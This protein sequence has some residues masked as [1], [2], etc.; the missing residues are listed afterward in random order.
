MSYDWNKTRDILRERGLTQEID[1]DECGSVD[2]VD[3]CT[4]EDPPRN[5]CADCHKK[6]HP[7]RDASKRNW[8]ESFD[9]ESETETVDEQ[10]ERDKTGTD[11]D[12]E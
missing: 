7:T 10:V 9:L 12:P 4:C 6:L 3:E 11:Q 1:C 8:G 2:R 5:L